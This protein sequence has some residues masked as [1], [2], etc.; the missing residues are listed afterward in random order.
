MLHATNDAKCVNARPWRLDDGPGIAGKDRRNC[1]RSLESSRGWPV[2]SALWRRNYRHLSALSSSQLLKH[3]WI[4]HASTVFSYS[5]TAAMLACF[6]VLHLA[7]ATSVAASHLFIL[8][9]LAEWARRPGGQ[10][11]TFTHKET[12]Q[13]VGLSYLLSA[14]FHRQPETLYTVAA[15]HFREAQSA[16]VRLK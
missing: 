3:C 2:A 5:H 15:G 8:V 16:L 12:K 1:F 13:A 10:P 4:V 9:T 14:I 7:V 11:L 6:T